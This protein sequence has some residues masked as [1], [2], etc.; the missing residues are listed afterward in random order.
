[1]RSSVAELV[2]SVP[3]ERIR[4]FCIIAHVD[5]GKS[6]LADR[7]MES[8]GA[9]RAEEARAQLLDSLSVE[10][11]RGI[12]VKAQTVSLLH[13][14]EQ[15]PPRPTASTRARARQHGPRPR[16]SRAVGRSSCTFST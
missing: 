3:P 5:H 13:R 4:N 6:T 11:E 2:C 1:M 14:D 10:R 15:A 16:G 12:T 8:T 9:V 7:L